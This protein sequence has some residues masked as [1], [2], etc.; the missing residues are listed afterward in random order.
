MKKNFIIC[1]LLLAIICIFI[2][3]VLPSKYILPVLMYHNID[4]QKDILSVSPKDFDRQMK[5]LKDNK[6]N[7]IKFG[8]AADLLINKK[9]IPPKT[10]VVTFDDGRENNYTQ[11]F[12]ILKKYNI[13]ATMFV[14]PGHS[15]LPGY[16]TGKQIRELSDDNIEIGSHTLNDVWL[17]GCEDKKLDEEI[18]GSKIALEQITDKKIDVF[19]YPVGGVDSNARSAVIRSGY[20]AACIASSPSNFGPRDIYSL[21]RVKV[22]GNKSKNIF[23]FWFYVSGYSNS[24]NDIKYIYKK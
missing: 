24:V 2:A 14:I 23:A 20:K 18:L 9:K 1:F 22:S 7:V 15:G 3:V 6:Y 19:C 13:A 8:E 11:A 5:F 4:E 10:V 17:P 21:R 16:M 12:L